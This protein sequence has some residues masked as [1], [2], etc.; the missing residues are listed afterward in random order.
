MSYPIEV[1]AEKCTLQRRLGLTP[2]E[3]TATADFPK[4][5]I[6]I[7]TNK[8]PTLSEGGAYAFYFNSNDG[9]RA[10]CH[11]GPAISWGAKGRIESDE[12]YY[13]FNSGSLK[14]TELDDFFEVVKS[15]EDK[16]DALMRKEANAY[17]E[18]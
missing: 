12:I 17:E 15:I 8:I 11:V 3:R 13:H 5:K 4:G 18:I 1:V 7:R 14:K 2:I 10:V 16:V 9:H 6:T